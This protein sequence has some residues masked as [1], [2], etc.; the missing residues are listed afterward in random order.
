MLTREVSF[1]F[2]VYIGAMNVLV[3]TY[4]RLQVFTIFL[5]YKKV[6]PSPQYHCSQHFGNIGFVFFKSYMQFE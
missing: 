4:K 1:W 5:K 2:N 3:N 6:T